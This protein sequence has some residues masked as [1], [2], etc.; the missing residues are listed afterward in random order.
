[1]GDLTL[2]PTSDGGQVFFK[3]N[4]DFQ[5]TDALYNSAYVA[6]CSDPY[7]GNQLTVSSHRL[8]SRLSDLF[9]NNITQQ[10]RRESEIIATEALDYFLTENIAETLVVE[11]RILSPYAILILVKIA[12]PNGANSSFAFE[13]NWKSQ[14]IELDFSGL[15]I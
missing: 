10:T 1:M 3:P 4:G 15:L 8:K 12:Q 7:W 6:L 5:T 11:S 13:M 14:A 2:L 9:K